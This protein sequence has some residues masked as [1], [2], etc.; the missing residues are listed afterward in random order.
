MS[1]IVLCFWVLTPCIQRFNSSSQLGEVQLTLLGYECNRS[2]LVFPGILVIKKSLWSP[3]HTLL[4]T[5]E[6]QQH[7]I[8]I[9]LSLCHQIAVCVMLRPVNK[10]VPERPVTAAMLSS[11]LTPYPCDFCMA[12]SSL[13]TVTFSDFLTFLFWK[14]VPAAPFP[15]LQCFSTLDHHLHLLFTFLGF[16]L[17]LSINMLIF[18][19]C[20]FP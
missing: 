7:D 17:L 6:E 10:A 4:D 8:I 15:S 9:S 11:Q 1:L 5:N 12:S 19:F 14:K 16:S 3:Q 2:C 20:W 13:S 18:F